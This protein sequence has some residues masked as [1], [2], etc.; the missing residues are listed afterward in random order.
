MYVYVYMYV[1]VCA[2]FADCVFVDVCVTVTY[3]HIRVHASHKS[4]RLLTFA[5]FFQNTFCDG[6]INETFSQVIPA[7]I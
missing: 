2:A 1:C 4:Y 3:M 7:V 5:T 6:K